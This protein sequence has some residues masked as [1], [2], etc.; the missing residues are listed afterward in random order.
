[1][2]HTVEYERYLRRR[3]WEDLHKDNSWNMTEVDNDDDTETKQ[4]E[5]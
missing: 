5:V 3:R 1:M 4:K 2:R